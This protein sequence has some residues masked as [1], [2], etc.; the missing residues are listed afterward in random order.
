MGSL[1]DL[2][3]DE[4]VRRALCWLGA[5]TIRVV[6]ATSRWTVVG[7]EAPR[8]FWDRS[9]AFILCFWHGRLMMM[10]YCWD[11]RFPI[12]TLTSNHPDGRLIAR[13]TA[14][15]GIPTLVGSSR[16]GGV[17]ALRAM[18]RALKAGESIGLTPD[19]PRGPRMRA[20]PGAVA[21]ARLT[22]A[23]IL[24]V[25][26]ST[27]RGRNL[28]SWDRFLLAWPFG[29][30]VVVWGEPIRV[31]PGLDG[32]GLEAARRRL[33]DA[34]N[35]VTAEADRRCGRTLIEPAPEGTSS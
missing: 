29:R 28:G 30:G 26:F 19:G 16:R 27:D 32:P 18:A 13:T 34:L 20:S 9:E 31:D 23:A 10:P 7:S 3:R 6:H 4:S 15:F 25:A 22:G 24:P 2:G 14:H 12:R 17:S 11:R 33:E 21:L 8:R 35:A 5:Q 1:R